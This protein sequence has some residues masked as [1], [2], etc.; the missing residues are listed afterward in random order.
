MWITSK[1]PPGGVARRLETRF[2]DIFFQVSGN[3]LIL[4][5]GEVEYNSI[6]IH[7]IVCIMCGYFLYLLGGRK[8]ENGELSPSA[9]WKGEIKRRNF[10]IP[11]ELPIREAKKVRGADSDI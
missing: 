6:V 4:D 2:R 8:V 3:L 9:L 11:P 5:P 1:R 7:K 10:S